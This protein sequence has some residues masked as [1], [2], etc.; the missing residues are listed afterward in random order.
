MQRVEAII[1]S[2]TM[3]ERRNPKVLNASRKKRV[4]AGSGVEVR[5]VNEVLKQ[6]GDMQKLMGQVRKGRF[7]GMAGG[8]VPRACRHG[9][10]TNK[11][12]LPQLSCGRLLKQPSVFRQWPSV[13]LNE[14]A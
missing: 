10:R 4:A 8:G 7:P 9:A 12:V 1:N 3:R 2:M 11:P 13:S 5:D 14:D 6:F